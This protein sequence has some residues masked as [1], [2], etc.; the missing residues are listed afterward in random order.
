MVGAP[1]GLQ[2]A[3]AGGGVLL[4]SL[5]CTR[6]PPSQEGSTPRVRS[7]ELDTALQIDDIWGCDNYFGTVGQGLENHRV[8]QGPDMSELLV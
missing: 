8:A 1:G 7:A 5:P 3:E 6:W 2:W 4:N